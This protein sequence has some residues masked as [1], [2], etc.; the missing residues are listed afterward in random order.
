MKCPW[1]DEEMVQGVLQSAE[2]IYFT[3]RERKII[4]KAIVKNGDI[5]LNDRDTSKATCTAYNCPK[6]E[7]IV[8][9]YGKNNTVD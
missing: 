4:L 8:V 7:R 5:V 9:D 1:C 3:K 6:C 2:E